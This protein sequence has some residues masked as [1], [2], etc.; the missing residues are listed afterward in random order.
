MKGVVLATLS[1]AALVFSQACGG[2]QCIC[3]PYP[4]YSAVLLTEKDSGLVLPLALYQSIGVMLPGSGRQIDSSDHDRLI[5]YH[6]TVDQTTG[7]TYAAFTPEAVIYW[8]R[9]NRLGGRVELFAP[10]QGSH[11]EWHVT[12]MIGTDNPNLGNFGTYYGSGTA[13]VA[14]GQSFVISWTVG[15]PAPIITDPTVLA[16][17]TL[18]VTVESAYR[19]TN[20][21]QF[22]VLKTFMQQLFVATGRGTA[23][24]DAP[25]ALP[26][27][28][29]AGPGM[30][31]SS[32]P[33]GPSQKVS[34]QDWS[35]WTCSLDG[36]CAQLTKDAHF[37]PGGHQFSVPSTRPKP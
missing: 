35:G 22:T 14:P 17:A 4:Q 13:L 24:I 37:L 27:G 18:P 5:P 10:A 8:D 26:L 30:M 16:A 32:G 6:S 23:Q 25:N 34:V 28:C 9:L 7:S 1:T 2:P 29:N 15:T 21:P 31:C 19:P 33:V 20:Q 3:S 12:V 36:G 11:H